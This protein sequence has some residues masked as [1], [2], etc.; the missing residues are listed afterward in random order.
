MQIENQKYKDT[1]F[2]MLF[3]NKAHLLELY[4]AINGTNY[5]NP[6]DLTITTLSGETFL[7]VKNDLSF[8]INDNLNI[9]EH[10]STPCPNIP[11]RD[12]Y[13]L[14]ANLKKL[15]PT[16]KLYGPNMIKIPTPKFIMFYN[17]VTSMEDKVTFCLS[18]MFSKPV[19]EL[20]VE[21]KVTALNINAGHNKELME[22][23]KTLKGYS[24]FVEKVRKYKQEAEEEYDSSHSTPLKLLADKTEVMNQLV[25]SAISKTIDE[26]IQESILKEFF[27][28]YRKE[29][30]EVGVLEYSYERHMQIV[31]DESY[32]SGFNNG[33]S[34]GHDGGIQDTNDLYS[35]LKSQGRQDDV[36]KAIDDS[37]Y[38]DKLF[39]EYAEWKKDND[40]NS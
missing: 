33:F 20:S 5:T 8:I 29:I 3:N 16:E 37:D 7:K 9:F 30:I 13:Y 28:D 4:N 12:L 27:A 2:R 35:W 26:C 21:L 39:E 36:M 1:V 18:D 10:Q 14:S 32:N 38:L 17:G 19:K 31:Q 40:K 25:K 6:E 15:Y 34:S 24:I 22:A 11:L 23:C